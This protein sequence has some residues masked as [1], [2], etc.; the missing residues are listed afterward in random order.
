MGEVVSGDV[1]DWARDLAALRQLLAGTDPP[2]PSVT[3]VVLRPE[4]GAARA[5]DTDLQ[6][7]TAPQSLPDNRQAS[8]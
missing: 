2:Q 7:P 3:G 8:A 4:F 1:L 5:R 6:P